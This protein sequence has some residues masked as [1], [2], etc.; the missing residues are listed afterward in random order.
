MTLYVTVITSAL[1]TLIVTAD[2]WAVDLHKAA[3]ME[4]A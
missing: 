2:T 4:G 3:Q 1:L